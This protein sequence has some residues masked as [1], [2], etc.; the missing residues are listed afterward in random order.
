MSK[1]RH[2][3]CLYKVGRVWGKG[4]KSPLKHEH[5]SSWWSSYSKFDRIL[6]FR[7]TTAAFKDLQR[8]V[9]IS[10]F[11]L[12]PSHL[13]HSWTTTDSIINHSSW[14]ST[15]IIGNRQHTTDARAF[16]K[17]SLEIVLFPITCFHHLKGLFQVLKPVCIS[18][19]KTLHC[20]HHMQDSPAQ[21]GTPASKVG[22]S[23]TFC[24]RAMDKLKHIYQNIIFS[25]LGH[26]L[27]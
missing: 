13:L 21:T 20:F 14:F 15:S 2:M 3:I 25:Y 11:N 5:L 4:L 17:A 10:V 27:K 18:W 22:T 12:K 19:V 7:I 26:D 23:G 16:L 6:Y 1:L 24:K 9:V 8:L